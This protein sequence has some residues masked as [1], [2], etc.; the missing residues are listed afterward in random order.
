MGRVDRRGG[1]IEAGGTLTK[2]E[3]VG[4]DSFG[5]MPLCAAAPIVCPVCAIDDDFLTLMR[6]DYQ[7]DTV[8]T[9]VA[10]HVDVCE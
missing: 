7:S 2:Q 9:I 5:N 6:K 1:F 10:S 3:Q 8:I 4:R